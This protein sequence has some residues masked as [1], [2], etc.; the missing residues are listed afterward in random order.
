MGARGDRFRATVLFWPLLFYVAVTVFSLFTAVDMDYS[1]KELRS[2]VLRG[3]LF[4]YA[5]V[6]LIQEADNLKQ[7]WG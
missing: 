3:L 5:G 7:F 2:E 6:H 4:F 1:L